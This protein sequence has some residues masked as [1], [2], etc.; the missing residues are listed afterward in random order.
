M[1][2]LG[3]VFITIAEYFVLLYLVRFRSRK[4]SPKRVRTIRVKPDPSP[5]DLGKDCSTGNNNKIRDDDG[6]ET[7]IKGTKIEDL[8]DRVFLLTQPVLFAAFA[9]AYVV[10]IK[11]LEAK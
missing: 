5:N 7:D 9:A 6:G 4:N 3:F 2:C 8:V 10:Y 1:S 11:G